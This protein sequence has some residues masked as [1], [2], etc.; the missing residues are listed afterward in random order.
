[1]HPMCLFFLNECVTKLSD[2]SCEELYN[3]EKVNTIGIYVYLSDGY[4]GI[5]FS[6]WMFI[7]FVCNLVEARWFGG[8]IPTG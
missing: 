6:E 4:V 8:I 5:V 3:A 7:H 2:Y 1:M